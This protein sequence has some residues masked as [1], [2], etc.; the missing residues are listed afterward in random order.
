[1]A[2][3]EPSPNGPGMGRESVRRRLRPSAAILLAMAMGLIAGYLDL[4]ILVGKK[5]FWNHP[6]YFW[7]ARDSAWSVPLVHAILLMVPGVLVAVVNRIRPG[8]VSLR[9]GAWLFATLAFWGAL[10][11]LPLYGACTLILAVGLGKVIGDAIAARAGQKRRARLAMVGMLGL[12]IVLAGAS[13][14]WQKLQ[15]ARSVAALPAA[16][17]GA[18]NVILIVWDTVRT[19]SL[20]LYGYERNT[21]PNLAFWS[22]RGVR[23]NQALAPAPWTYPSHSSFFTGHWPYQLNTQWKY[24]L[25]APVPT[26]AEYLSAQGYQTAGFAANT[27]CCTYESGLDRGFQHYEDYVLSPTM[28]L[29]RTIPG[30]WILEHL[31]YRGNY[32]ARKWV[33]LQSRDAGGINDAFLGWLGGRRRDRPFFAFLNYF[34]AHDPYLPPAGFV[35]RFGTWPE[36]KR[37]YEMLLGIEGNIHDGLGP[38]DVAMTRDRYD[39]CLAYL[40]E[41][42]GRL[43]GTLQGQGLLDETLVIVTSDHGESFGEH[44]ML[45][46]AT[47]LYLEQT[48][49]PLVILDPNAPAG[50][51]VREPVSLRDLPATVVD[52]LGLAEHAPFPGH[53]LASHWR[54][55]AG[56]LPPETTPAFA[57]IA[58]A[59]A[60]EPQPQSE[61]R[62]LGRGGFQMSLLANGHRYIR[63]GMGAEFLY[64]LRTDPFENEDLMTTSE[65]SALVGDFRR[66]LLDLLTTERGTT[67]VENAYLE[68]Y[69]RWLRSLVEEE[70]PR[71]EASMS[72]GG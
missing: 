19:R 51:I 10:L 66:M 43:L 41:Q 46:H 33:R 31:V 14:G 42:L 17:T 16:K 22:R 5:F 6:K 29:G 39:D 60:F 63:D 40:D 24:V 37:D 13:T 71:N 30:R 72:V 25:D 56:S 15:E 70:H 23:Y 12:L 50:R 45:G 68:P 55:S 32:A 35:G 69:R 11:R 36:S 53:S 47:N 64:D 44:G 8:L 26:L 48:A 9:M 27:N 58:N 61:D 52:R 54:P 67:E 21:S 59:A 28:L 65:G 20:G 4:L 38:R 3:M 57:E 18:R 7:T 34:D 2:I 62:G 1:M 49:V